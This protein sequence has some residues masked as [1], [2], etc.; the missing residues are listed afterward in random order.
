MIRTGASKRNGWRWY[1][2]RPTDYTSQFQPS[3]AYLGLM[4]SSPSV[5]PH[6]ATVRASCLSALSAATHVM[7]AALR[8]AQQ[9]NLV[10]CRRAYR[11]SHSLVAADA[12]SR[13]G[14]GLHRAFA[15]LQALC[16]SRPRN[17]GFSVT[18]L[19]YMYTALH[20]ASD[21]LSGGDPEAVAMYFPRSRRPR[22]VMLVAGRQFG[23]TVAQVALMAILLTACK[24]EVALYAND[25][26]ALLHSVRSVAAEIHGY[27]RALDAL[28]IDVS[29]SVSA[30]QVRLSNGS[31]LRGYLTKGRGPH[32]D[33]AIGDEVAF[34]P[35]ERYAASVQ[36][37][38]S[39]RKN[40]FELAITTP[41]ESISGKSVYEAFLEASTRPGSETHIVDGTVSCA[42]PE[43]A[44]LLLCPHQRA[45]FA[46]W[47]NVAGIEE[48]LRDAADEEARQRVREENMGVHRA[49]HSPAFAPSL[50]DGFRLG[51]GPFGSS[52]TN[53]GRAHVVVGVDPGFTMSST[54]MVAVCHVPQGGL[55][56]I[57]ATAFGD[58]DPLSIGPR[59]AAFAAC[60]LERARST[61]THVISDRAIVVVERVCGSE[62]TLAAGITPA[63]PVEVFRHRGTTGVNTTRT[64][65]HQAVTRV[66]GLLQRGE[67]GW[68]GRDVLN[69]EFPDS[70]AAALSD[71]APLA[72]NP[73]GCL[74]EQVRA[75]T[76]IGPPDATPKYSGKATGTHS[77]DLAMAL[78]IAVHGI[79][80]RETSGGL[81]RGWT[82]DPKRPRLGG[83][84]V[85]V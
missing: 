64:S 37:Q 13:R 57:G 43:C 9:G 46:P 3:T 81:S 4:S 47:V 63:D 6:A 45:M 73:V 53:G 48:R 11:I 52:D 28:D 32:A 54:A 60:A 39:A 34:V 25:A 59:A 55:F 29:V 68:W 58:G 78:L 76:R 49:A 84:A 79:L 44:D 36:K 72:E 17:E 21:H 31:S 1:C 30:Y 82:A 14:R 41:Y 65:K 83:S 19:E 71:A 2:T 80:L 51:A 16:R 40:S 74:V 7:S 5:G 12:R 56:V 10:D 69:G 24:T 23:K 35:F 50:L 42:L 66:T 22:T 33:C 18:Q 67:F 75:F 77:D 26:D 15:A 8:R 38:L 70:L 85:V 62:E 61:G 27:S 20:A